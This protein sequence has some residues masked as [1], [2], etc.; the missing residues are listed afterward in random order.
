MATFLEVDAA[1]TDRYQTTVPEPVRR[2]LNLRKRDRV[3]YEITA[4]GR[5]ELT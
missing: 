5:V 2:V 1:L 4:D 3:R